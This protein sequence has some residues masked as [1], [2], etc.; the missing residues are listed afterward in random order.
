MSSAGVALAEPW[1]NSVHVR[2]TK[3]LADALNGLD[4]RGFRIGD[5]I[6]LEDPLAAMLI[7]EK[8]AVTADKAPETAD[9]RSM[10]DTRR[11]RR[12][13]VARRRRLVK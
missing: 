1:A 6:Q 8:W 2:L 4:L 7:A 11:K 12:T 13:A 9:D 5:V 3:K 10:R